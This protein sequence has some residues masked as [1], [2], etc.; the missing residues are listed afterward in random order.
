MLYGSRRRHHAAGVRRHCRHRNPDMLHRGI[1]PSHERWATFLGRLAYVVIDEAHTMRGVFG[2]HVGL[3]DANRSPRKEIRRIL[4]EEWAHARLYRSNDERC[5][6]FAGWWRR[7]HHQR[8]PTS[9]DGLILM[10]VLVD[11]GH[12][13]DT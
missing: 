12:W 10:A 13:N 4:L 11:N 9:L 3:A 5:R 1:L 8:P 6:A 7:G 2:S